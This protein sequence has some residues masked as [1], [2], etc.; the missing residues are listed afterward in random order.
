MST[1]LLAQR[2]YVTDPLGETI[3]Y[4]NPTSA[5]GGWLDFDDTNGY[6]PENVFWDNNSAPQGEYLV[7]LDYYSGYNSSNYIV[8]VSIGS[9]V[10]TYSG[11]IGVDETIEICSFNYFG[12]R[13]V[14]FNKINYHKSRNVK[15]SKM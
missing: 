1:F 9:N 2:A 4:Y 15:P 5:S 8:S 6:G 11:S 7:E 13:N 10:E 14:N 3:C 12:S